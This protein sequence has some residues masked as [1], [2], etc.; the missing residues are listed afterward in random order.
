MIN[1]LKGIFIYSFGQVLSKIIT[2]CLLPLLTSYL[3]AEDYGLIGAS[4]LMAQCLTGFFGLGMGV[5]IGRYYWTAIDLKEK[6]GIIWTVFLLLVANALLF[7]TICF[8]FNRFFTWAVF[9]QDIYID[10]FFLTLFATALNNVVMPFQLYFRLNERAVFV[11]T[12]SIIEIISSVSLS[13][14]F[15]V[16]MGW[17]CYGVLLGGLIGQSISGFI[18][19]IASCKELHFSIQFKLIPEIMIK[20]G[21]P[22]VAGLLG[23]FFTS[24]GSTLCP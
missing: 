5:V 4:S 10:I 22:Y 3:T 23:Y 2:F 9:G 15:V 21:Y 7:F 13:L 1:L 11:V 12:C 8:A 16:T 14:Y 6:H 17:G 18:F 19:F 20:M 24:R